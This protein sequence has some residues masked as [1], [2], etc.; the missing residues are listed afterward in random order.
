MKIVN[1]I[2]EK[3]IN[4]SFIVFYKRFIHHNFYE[5]NFNPHHFNVIYFYFNFF[6]SFIQ[7]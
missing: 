3:Q 5:Y 7:V 1:K 2:E 6:L 4:F